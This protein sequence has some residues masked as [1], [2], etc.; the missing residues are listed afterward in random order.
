MVGCGDEWCYEPWNW[1]ELRILLGLA[2]LGMAGG[3]AGNPYDPVG[4]G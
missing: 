3:Y 2:R 1:M 4:G